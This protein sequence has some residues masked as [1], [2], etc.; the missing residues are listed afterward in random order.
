MTWEVLLLLRFPFSFIHLLHQTI[1]S[2]DTSSFCIISTLS[3][4]NTNT[5]NTSTTA[6]MLPKARSFNRSTGVVVGLSGT[7]AAAP[8]LFFIPGAEERLA[9]QAAKWGP[10]WNRGLSRVTPAVQRGAA[11]VEPRMQ[12]TV[13]AVEP[14]LKKAAM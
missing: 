3:I 13:K 10:R 9:A 11:K 2:K 6:I 1:N 8:L 12:K 5:K 4:N 7:C 14:P